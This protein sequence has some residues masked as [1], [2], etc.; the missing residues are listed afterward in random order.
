MAGFSPSTGNQNAEKASGRVREREKEGNARGKNERGSIENLKRKQGSTTQKFCIW[1]GVCVWKEERERE[2][3][4]EEETEKRQRDGERGRDRHSLQL[5]PSAFSLPPLPP[6]FLSPFFLG[7]IV[8]L[9]EGT[10]YTA[11]RNQPFSAA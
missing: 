6:F 7:G 9:A 2:R 4:R 3:E 1:K 11:Q 10:A 5:E 8:A